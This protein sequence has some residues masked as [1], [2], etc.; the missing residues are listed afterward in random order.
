MIVWVNDSLFKTI[1]IKGILKDLDIYHAQA[2]LCLLN[3]A[4]CM[5]M[6]DLSGSSIDVQESFAFE[7]N[8]TWLI[9]FVGHLVSEILPVFLKGCVLTGF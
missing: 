3:S 9:N 4:V 6:G 2:P 1:D 8:F 5:L 7:S